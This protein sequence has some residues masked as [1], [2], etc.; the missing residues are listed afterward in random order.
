MGTVH[1]GEIKQLEPRASN[2]ISTYDKRLENLRYGANDY[3]FKD[4]T[5]TAKGGSATVFKIK[6]RIDNNF[7]AL[8]QLDF[9]INQDTSYENKELF[10]RELTTLDNLDH[11]L[12][13]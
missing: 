9:I 10:T 4:K 12:V 7:F 2:R 11:P 6:R 8:K 5:T 1:S 13:V 3:Y